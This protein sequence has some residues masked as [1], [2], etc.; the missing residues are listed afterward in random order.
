LE[1]LEKKIKSGKLT[2]QHINNK[3]YNK[4]LKIEGEPSISI[5]KEKYNDDNKWDGL[6]G[7]R[8]NT[9]LSK[10]EVIKQYHQLWQIEKAFRISNTI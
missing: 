10:E 5:D 3:G 4:Y 1:K 2:K 9:H 8:T 6:K 7:Y